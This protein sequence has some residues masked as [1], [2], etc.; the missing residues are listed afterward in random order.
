MALGMTKM[1]KLNAI[2]KNLA[3]VETLGAVSFVC[4]DK[5]GTLTQ[6]KMTVVKAFTNFNYVDLEKLDYHPSRH[7]VR[8]LLLCC[9]ASIS[10]DGTEI[11]DPTEV[12]LVTFANR[13]GKDKKTSDAKYPRV[14]EHEFDSDR[15]LMT[16]VHMYKNGTISYTKGSTDEL[17]KRC[18]KILVDGEARPITE[19]DK[20]L[21][22]DAMSE[23]S[24]E[25]LRVLS[26]AL[27]LDNKDA[28]ESDLTYVG[29][30]GMI[31][32]ERTEVVE[33]VK[34]FKEAGVTTIMITGDHKDTALAIA[35]KLGIATQEDECIMGAELNEMSDETLAE[36]VK[37]L[38][39][40]ARVSPEH[41]VR[42][43][44]A[45]Q[46]NGYIVSMTGKLRCPV[47]Q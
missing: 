46:A 13:F 29:M 11:G 16:T 28:E 3:A 22:M 32:P 4:S 15:K 24:Y 36:K 6:N 20:K 35:K 41:K 33:S 40:F 37:K 42:I 17:L 45:L 38:R 34:V 44:K 14:N 47:M 26:L 43:V 30:V 2:V 9:D 21:I 27:R 8:G 1:A 5:T 25:A 7:L 10:P 39:V 31:D 18:T 23:M 12:A 19:N